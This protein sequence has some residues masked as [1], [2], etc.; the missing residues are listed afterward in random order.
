VKFFFS[1]AVW[2]TPL[3]SHYVFPPPSPSVMPD[4]PPAPPSPPLRMPNS[5]LSTTDAYAEDETLDDIVI[6]PEDSAS[7]QQLPFGP[8]LLSPSIGGST[9]ANVISAVSFSFTDVS[10]GLTRKR[11]TLPPLVRSPSQLNILFPFLFVLL[12]SYIVIDFISVLVVLA[13]VLSN[14]GSGGRL[15]TGRLDAEVDT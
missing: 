9:L 13:E 6:H 14:C 7:R 1:G 10:T 2:Q 5:D 4:I 11:I 15:E 8:E 3:T 12:G